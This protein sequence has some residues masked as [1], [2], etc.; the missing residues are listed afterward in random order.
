MVV[1]VT[2]GVAAGK[3]AF[4]NI[5]QDFGYKT[6]SV[7]K[8]AHYLLAPGS[9]ALDLLVKEFGKAII[10]ED[11][12]IDREALREMVLESP[13]ARRRLEELLHPLILKDL[14][15]KLM[16]LGSRGEEIVFVEIPLLFEA[17]WDRI[18]NL[19]VAVT[20]PDE[21]R[22]ARLRSRGRAAEDHKRLGLNQFPQ[23]RKAA[24]ADLVVENRGSLRDLEKEARRILKEARH[25]LE[26]RASS[27][28][29]LP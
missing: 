2:G 12:G 20:A 17:G 10:A 9:P 13:G 21:M 14:Q 15:E 23:D 24:M 28:G 3:T 6:I 25:R 26:R 8:L 7:D 27:G 4:I 1:G 29:A 19:T 22:E 5:L 18:C 16:E 11:G